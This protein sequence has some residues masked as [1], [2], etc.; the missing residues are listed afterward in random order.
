MGDEDEGDAGFL[1]Q[2]LQLDTHRLS[3]FQVEC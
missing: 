2:L 3:E 1:L